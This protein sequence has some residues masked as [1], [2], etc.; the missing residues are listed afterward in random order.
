MKKI[1]AL[2]SLTQVLNGST[3]IDFVSSFTFD[4]FVPRNKVARDTGFQVRYF[5]QTF[6]LYFDYFYKPE[7][8]KLFI[9]ADTGDGS[10]LAQVPVEKRILL[11]FEP[12]GKCSDE[13]EATYGRIYTFNDDLID[14]KKYFKLFFPTLRPMLTDLPSFEDK[15]FCVMMTHRATSE[16]IKIAKFLETKPY[17]EFEYY[18][19]HQ[20]IQTDRYRG[21]IPGHPLSQ[22]KF[23]VL[24]QF[25]F[26]MCFEN[27]MINGYVSEKIFT[28]FTA[29]CVPIYLGAPN[30]ETYIPKDCFI[31]Y[32]DFAND[33]EL[34]Q[35]LKSMTKAQYE[36]Y[37]ENIAAYLTSE[38]GSLFSQKH[39][40][41]IVADCVTNSF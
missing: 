12:H 6:D 29:G 5:R 3:R 24:K 34:Y 33:E 19:F 22:E 18:G 40:S 41:E 31:D 15:K 27:T 38:M 1:I 25:R 14:G 36:R 37:L 8:A 9:T 16:R 21:Q 17:D 11:L 20:A 10:K 23:D 32:R 35:F 30:V 4:E 28:C 7:I 26:C 39:F 2:L 13:V